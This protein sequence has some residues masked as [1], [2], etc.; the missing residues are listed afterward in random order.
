LPACQHSPA[1]RNF[2]S[3]PTPAH[4]PALALYSRQSDCRGRIFRFCAEKEALILSFQLIINYLAPNDCRRVW[5][6]RALARRRRGTRRRRL[7]FRPFWLRAILKSPASQIKL[8]CGSHVRLYFSSV[9]L[10]A[11]VKF[12]FRRR[13]TCFTSLSWPK[14]HFTA[15]DRRRW[16]RKILVYSKSFCC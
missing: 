2:V 14:S 13:M 5:R 3:A 6:E 4:T 1:C 7:C 10:A 12:I 9:S 11:C 15:C 8:N 16:W